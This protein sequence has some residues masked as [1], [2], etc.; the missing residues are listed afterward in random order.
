[1]AEYRRHQLT[2]QYCTLNNNNGFGLYTTGGSGTIITTC[3]NPWVRLQQL[4]DSWWVQLGRI[5]ALLNSNGTMNGQYQICPVHAGGS[6]TGLCIEVLA[7]SYADGA[8]IDQWPWNGGDNQT[9]VLNNVGTNTFSALNTRSGKALEVPGASLVVGTVLDQL[10]YNGGTNQQW[11]IVDAGSA[12]GKNAGS[13]TG[14]YTVNA[15]HD[16]LSMDVLG[17]SNAQGTRIDQYTPNGQSNQQFYLFR[18]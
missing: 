13:G 8:Q 2:I 7:N 18:R 15:V 10:T 11:A 5:P 3:T 9:W 12:T 4:R 17:N 6:N 1:M 14:Y 16:G